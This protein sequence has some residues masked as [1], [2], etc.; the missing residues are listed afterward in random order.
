M[1]LAVI[2]Y[3][4]SYAQGKKPMFFP[5]KL[6]HRMEFAIKGF[7]KSSIVHVSVLYRSADEYAHLDLV[8]LRG[9]KVRP[10]QSCP[11]SRLCT[12]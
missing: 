9:Q 11:T 8:R 1:Y 12:R 2:H 10:T 4:N 3:A 7:L 5:Q 6:I